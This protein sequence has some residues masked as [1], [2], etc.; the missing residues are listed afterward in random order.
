MRSLAALGQGSLAVALGAYLALS[1]CEKTHAPAV[2]HNWA[3]PHRLRVAESEDPPTLNPYRSDL[4]VVHDLTSLVYS[5]LVTADDRGHL[6]GDLAARV[7]SRKNGGIS[8]DGRT[9][10]YHLRRGV[11]WQDRHAFGAADVIA[12]WR[13]IVALR[14][15]TADRA[16]FG[17]IQ[18]ISQAG[19][20]EIVVRLYH[21]YPPFLT[22]FFT[23]LEEGGVPVLPASA[24]G[25][26]RTSEERN[27]G[28]GPFMVVAWSRGDE[29]TLAPFGAYFRGKPRLERIDVKFIPNGQTVLAEL[30]SHTIDLVAIPQAPLI[31][32]YR[33]VPGVVVETSPAN[34]QA[35]LMMN[36]RRPALSD[37]VVRRALALALPYDQILAKVAHGLYAAPRS[38]QAS[39]SLGYFAERPRTFDPTAANALLDRTHWKIG[40]DGVRARGNFRLAFTLATFTGVATTEEIALLVQAALRQVGIA[41]SIKPYSI[42][43]LYGPDGLIPKGKFDLVFDRHVLGRD[44]N[45]YD[46]LACDQ[47][48]PAGLNEAGF[49]DPAL[50][51]IERDGLQT[52]DLAARAATYRS[53][54]KRIWENVPFIPIYQGTTVTVRSASLKNFRPNATISPWWNA[55]QWDI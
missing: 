29:L 36:E 20:D 50:D 9:Y 39:E 13:A 24:L 47:I 46:T 30:K 32:A 31:A 55:W 54:Q 5:Y 52:E 19:K 15:P 14:V 53:A 12:S 51:A 41:V 21:R 26:P 35:V 28:T 34:W 23:P 22:H 49:C 17:R 6:I 48:Y 40:N 44:P 1:G 7:P 42:M 10:V 3:I 18:S 43:T 37:V 33:Q 25:S 2:S 16:V 8:A 38:T 27:I 11:L 4:D 45:A